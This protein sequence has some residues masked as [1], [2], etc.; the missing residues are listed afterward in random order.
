MLLSAFA[1]VLLLSISKVLPKYLARKALHIGS[2]TL[3]IIAYDKG[4]KTLIIIVGL[5]ALLALLSK[6]VTLPTMKEYALRKKKRRVDLGIMNFIISTVVFTM[7]EIPLTHVS[8]LYYADP[9]GAIVG[10]NIK[11]PGL[12]YS[13]KK[14]IGGT[15]AVIFTAFLNLVYFAKASYTDAIIWAVAVG[16]IELYSGEW[17]NV[18]IS[19]ILALRFLIFYSDDNYFNSKV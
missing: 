3:C 4:Y 2:G 14:S 1:L 9:M 8:P 12:P 15:L 18:A 11:T 19:G 13:G 5:I 16:L 6:K 7:L 17:D 10:R